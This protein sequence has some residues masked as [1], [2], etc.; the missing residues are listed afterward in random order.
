MPWQAHNAKVERKQRLAGV[1]QGS[2]N[3]TGAMKRRRTV[4][5]VVVEYK[6]ERRCAFVHPSTFASWIGDASERP[7]IYARSHP[8]LLVPVV[9]DSS[10]RVGNIA[11]SESMRINFEVVTDVPFGWSMWEGEANVLAE[12]VVDVR[13]RHAQVAAF[14]ANAQRIASEIGKVLFMAC[15]TLHEIFVFYCDGT[16]FVGRVSEAVEEEDDGDALTMPDNFRGRVEPSTQVLLTQ[17]ST[18][19]SWNLLNNPKRSERPMRANVIDVICSDD[20]WFPVKKKLLQPCIALTKHVLD[21]SSVRPKVKV[22]MDCCLFDR[23][24]LYLEQEAKG[25]GDVTIDPEHAVALLNAAQKL[26]LRGLED[27]ALAILGEFESRVRPE[28]IRWK[29]VIRRNGDGETLLCIDGMIFDVTRWLPEH[30]G[31]STIIPNQAK[32]KDSTVFFELFHSSRASFVY[33]KQ[34]YIGDLVPDDRCKVPPAS[35]GNPSDAFK[36]VLREYCTWRVYPV[37]K[38][39]KSF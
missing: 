22:D 5:L 39:H 17:D 30:P 12:L 24:L 4:S 35:K 1:V 10:I 19:G 18:R 2:D 15:V 32:N 16:E 27:L 37:D 3:G 38:V 6:E 25:M 21:D 9:A 11:L 14:S 28:G 31:G 34:F 33:L 29:E 26:K 7:L 23:V 20:E 36:D 8:Q 13:P